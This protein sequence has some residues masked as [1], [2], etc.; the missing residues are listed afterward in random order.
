MYVLPEG[1]RS[2][3][4]APMGPVLT[5]ELLLAAVRDVPRLA[6]VGDVVT[7]TLLEAGVVPQVMVIDGKTKRTEAVSPLDAADVRGAVEVRVVNEA[8]RIRPELW[9]AVA[10][11]FASRARTLIRVDGEEDLATLPCIVHAPEG[12]RVVYGQPG[13]GA[14]V[15]TVDQTTRARAHQLLA[16]MEVV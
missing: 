12:A 7:R 2:E 6:T 9:D 1:L 14:V 11:A 3:L 16:R 8:A 10:A 13:Q 15:V 4:Q 5:G